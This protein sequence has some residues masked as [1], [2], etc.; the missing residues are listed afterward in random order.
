MTSEPKDN[1]VDK[2]STNSGTSTNTEEIER[3]GQGSTYKQWNT[4]QYKS[5][6]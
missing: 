6:I 1:T 2:I 5:S 4:T 3:L